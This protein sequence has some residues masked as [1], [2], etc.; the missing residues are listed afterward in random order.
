LTAAQIASLRNAARLTAPDV[1]DK[2][3][4]GGTP[5]SERAIF[6]VGTRDWARKALATGGGQ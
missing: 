1:L 2:Q 6:F 4:Y 3:A 5:A